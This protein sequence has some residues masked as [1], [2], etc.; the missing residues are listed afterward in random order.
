MKNNKLCDPLIDK[1]TEFDK[2]E[3]N[4]NANKTGNETVLKIED[5]SQDHCIGENSKYFQRVNL[6][7]IDK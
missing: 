3:E 7:N 1:T 4:I 6:Y 2:T 5:K